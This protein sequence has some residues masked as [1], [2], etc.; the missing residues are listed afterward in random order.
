M[1]GTRGNKVTPPSK[2]PPAIVRP[3]PSRFILVVSLAWSALILIVLFSARYLGLK[4][5]Q[6]ALVCRLS[7]LEGLRLLRAFP[8]VLIAGLAVLAIFF[9]ARRD[10]RTV[11][12]A[13]A[14]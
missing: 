13:A 12:L 3:R 8:A 5:G 11:G 4:L 1:G 6:G 7:T 2:A 14:I 9:T 10:R